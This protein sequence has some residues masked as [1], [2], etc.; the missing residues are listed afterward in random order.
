MVK[1]RLIADMPESTAGHGARN[2][3]IMPVGHDGS[4]SLF[5]TGSHVGGFKP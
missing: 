4:A 2:R 5:Q 1:F 3:Q